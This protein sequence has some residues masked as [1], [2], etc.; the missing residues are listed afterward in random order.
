MNYSNSKTTCPVVIKCV[1]N[2]SIFSVTVANCY[3]DKDF[4]VLLTDSPSEQVHVQGSPC[5]TCADAHNKHHTS[6]AV[7]ASTQLCITTVFL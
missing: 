7:T 4:A 5:F 2:R 1:N 3:Q 6:Y